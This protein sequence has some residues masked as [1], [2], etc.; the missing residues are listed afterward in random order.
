MDLGCSGVQCATR[1][2]IT[3]ECGLPGPVK[4][5]YLTAVEEDIVVNMISPDRLSHA[6]ACA[7]SGHR[8]RHSSQ[9]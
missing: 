6:H 8:L 3:K 1:F 7:I 5:E 9:L 4:Q 2:T